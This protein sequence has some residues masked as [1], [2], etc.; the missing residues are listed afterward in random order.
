M[1]L[2]YLITLKNFKL[3]QQ[4]NLKRKKLIWQDGKLT[5][6]SDKISYHSESEDYIVFAFQAGTHVINATYNLKR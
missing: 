3:L 2:L 6:A 4:A 5:G 1:A